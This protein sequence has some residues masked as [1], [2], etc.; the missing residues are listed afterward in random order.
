MSPELWL[1]LRKNQHNT[2]FSKQCLWLEEGLC[3]AQPFDNCFSMLCPVA[4][5]FPFDYYYVFFC[6]S[7]AI[8]FLAMFSR[9][10]PINW[11]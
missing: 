10:G 11:L 4:A 3:G 8:V 9:Y 6:C 5:D 2:L 1:F 7:V